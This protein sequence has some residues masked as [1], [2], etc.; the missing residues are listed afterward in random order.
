LIWPI[1][2]RKVNSPVWEFI[3]FQ[4]NPFNNLQ[5]DNIFHHANVTNLWVE[6]GGKSYPEE[7]LDLDWDSCYFCLG[8]DAFQDYVFI[9]TD[10]IPY[11]SKK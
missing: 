5:K 4:T 3:V 1:I 6:M 9:K 10:S 11:I 8:Y 2:Y 7:C